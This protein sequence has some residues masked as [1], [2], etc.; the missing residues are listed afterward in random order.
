[1]APSSLLLKHAGL[2]VAVKGLFAFWW[3]PAQ[4]SHPAPPGQ[5]VRPLT[6]VPIP[7]S[8][9][10]GVRD[11]PGAER[12]ECVECAFCISVPVI[13][14]KSRRGVGLSSSCFLASLQR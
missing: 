7:V 13:S 3:G 1:M 9:S 5:P 2:F 4:P 6:T 14:S 8:D 10:E 11:N 12:V